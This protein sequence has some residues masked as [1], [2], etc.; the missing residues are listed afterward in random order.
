MLVIRKTNRGEFMYSISV[1]ANEINFKDLEKN[2]GR[3]F[4]DMLQ[5]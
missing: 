1:D 5:L 3:N 4:G 2:R